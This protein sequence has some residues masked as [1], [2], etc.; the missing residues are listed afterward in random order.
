MYANTFCMRSVF[1]L[2]ALVSGAG[3]HA[4]NCAPGIDPIQLVFSDA[5]SNPGD[6]AEI[7]VS[8][9]SGNT[10]PSTIVIFVQY[11]PAKLEPYADF[12][13]FTF[14]DAQGNLLTD[15]RGNTV[16]TRS[17]ACLLYT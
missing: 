10:Q 13:E 17:M 3:V 14:N 4:Q 8:I 16:F 12:Y 11:D 9:D 6:S 15:N 1:L 5:S 2:A 7:L